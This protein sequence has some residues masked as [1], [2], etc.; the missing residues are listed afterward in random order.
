MNTLIQGGGR[1]I[2]LALARQALTAGAERLV[3]T[4]R[5]PGN[6]AAHA[7]F[8]DDA[9][10][11]FIPLDITDDAGIRNA[12]GEIKALVPRLDRVICTSGILREGDINPE[13]RIADIDAEALVTLYR[14]NALG[15]VLLARELWPLLKGDHPLQFSAISARVGS[16]S[17]NRLGGWYSYRASKA[18]LNQFCLL[19]TSPSPRDGLLSRMPSSA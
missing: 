19:Y 5:D 13:K 8:G 10:V 18:A 2:G 6:S 11:T 3:I 16:I 7:E 14:V 9:R 1:G 15:P 17:D 4:A 12:A